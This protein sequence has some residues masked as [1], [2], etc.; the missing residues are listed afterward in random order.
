[1]LRILI[2]DDEVLV[3]YDL[4]QPV[5]DLGGVEIGPAHSLTAG[6]ALVESE[7][8]DFALID[9]NLGAERSTPIA[10]ALKRRGVPYVLISGYGR[11]HLA[12]ELQDAILLMKPCTQADVRDAI[13]TALPGR[14]WIG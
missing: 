12:P 6:L 4:A 9:V 2:V 1:M 14:I 3:A 10:E 5:E 11:A 7:Q 13:R 8:V